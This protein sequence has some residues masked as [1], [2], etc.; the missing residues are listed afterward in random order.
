[1]TLDQF[2]DYLRAEVQRQGSQRLL[3]QR[4]GVTESFLSDVLR[5]RRDPGPKLLAALGLRQ[6]V[7]IEP[8]PPEA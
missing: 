1:M 3:A 6:V 8:L 5:G 7:C 2:R 4:C